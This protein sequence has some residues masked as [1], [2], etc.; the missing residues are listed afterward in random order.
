MTILK[1]GDTVPQGAALTIGNFD[2]LHRGHQR[3]LSE[4]QAA[5]ARRRCPAGLVTFEPSPQLVIHRE[6]P[7]IL[8]PWPEKQR[9]LAASGVDFVYLLPF[10][11]QLRQL[12]AARFL[13]QM[14]LQPLRPAAL[15]IGADHR[16]GADRQGDAGLIAVYQQEYGFELTAVPEVVVDGAA[17]KSTR[18]RERLI[19][20][21]VRDA[22]A[23]LG[24][25]YTVY[26]RVVRGRQLGS[27]IGYPTVNIEPESAEK[28]IP[29]TGVY[30]VLVNA[31]AG[32]YWGVMNIGYRPTFEPEP[33]AGIETEQRVAGPTPVIEVHILDFAGELYDLPL[34]VEFVERLRPEKRFADAEELRN[35]IAADI[36]FARLILAENRFETQRRAET[37]TRSG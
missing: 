19:L 9:R 6:F 2:G 32:Q 3:L 4:L 27:R 21:A 14:I 1:P 31:A 25:Y 5:A 12:A 24:Y 11:E 29:A 36:T 37:R 18:I 33:A 15:V 22:A 35:Q 13:V 20:G 30:A 26:G 23:L 8:T 28:L 7:Y 34:A 17:V 16:F 10:S